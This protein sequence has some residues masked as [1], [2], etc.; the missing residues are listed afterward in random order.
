M[1]NEKTSIAKETFVLWGVIIVV[2]AGFFLIMYLSDSEYRGYRKTIE[3]GMPQEKYEKALRYF[4]EE[5]HLKNNKAH[6]LL[7]SASW[8]GHEASQL[9]LGQVLIAGKPHIKASESKGVFW[10]L[11]A[12]RQG[13][14]EA[15]EFLE[16]YSTARANVSVTDGKQSTRW[17]DMI[18]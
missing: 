10:L 16:E 3:S 5:N 4:S 7:E 8:E 15:K 12:A 9:L 11:R 2:I 13:N 18:P 17:L 14:L 1:P 6:A